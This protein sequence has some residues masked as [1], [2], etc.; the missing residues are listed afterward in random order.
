M[1]NRVFNLLTVLAIVAVVFINLKVVN[2]STKYGYL[3][4]EIKKVLAQSS[5][6]SSSGSYFY[7]NGQYWDNNYHWYNVIGSNWR[8]EMKECTKKI[9]SSSWDVAVSYKNKTG[10]EVEFDYHSG[11]YEITYNGE[12]V[13]CVGGD[14]N[15]WNGTDC[16]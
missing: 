9:T 1:K 16:V 7:F 10:Y 2:K 14:G 13:I 12:M 15:C 6:G 8:P 3:K 11:S 4:P 5:G